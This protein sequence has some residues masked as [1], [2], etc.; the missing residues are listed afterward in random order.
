METYRVNL[1]ILVEPVV[2]IILAGILFAEIPGL[3]FYMGA[4]LVFAGVVIALSR[5][6]DSPPKGNWLRT[7]PPAMEAT[8]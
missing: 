6:G 5:H 7:E 1:S 3:R 8:E 2:S 4:V